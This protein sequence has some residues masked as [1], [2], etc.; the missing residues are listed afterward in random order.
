MVGDILSAMEKLS[1]EGAIQTDPA[2]MV[3]PIAGTNLERDA[4]RLLKEV[5][6]NTGHSVEE[7]IE[8]NRLNGPAEAKN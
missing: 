4:L 3:A 6:R 2:S 8:N 5:A 7:V 1:L